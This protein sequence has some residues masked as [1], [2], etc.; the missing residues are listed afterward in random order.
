[1][2]VKGRDFVDLG[3]CHPHLGCERLEMCGTQEAIG[4]LDAM[5]VLDQVVTLARTIAEQMGNLGL[6]RRFELAPFVKCGRSS[7]ARPGAYQPLLS[8][9]LANFSHRSTSLSA[10]GH[11]QSAGYSRGY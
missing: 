11:R 5:Q 2:S 10:T 8:R 6:R 9:L 7:P 1:M 3:H 4:V